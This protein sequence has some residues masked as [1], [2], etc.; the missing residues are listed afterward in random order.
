M[1]SLRHH[2]ASTTVIICL[3]LYERHRMHV[4]GKQ[5]EKRLYP[6]AEAA[7]STHPSNLYLSLSC[8]QIAGEAARLL[9]H[10]TEVQPKPMPS[11]AACYHI[12]EERKLFATAKPFAVYS[13]SV[14]EKVAWFFA[15]IF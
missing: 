4:T 2:N 1:Q 14:R 11:D 13:R 6:Q 10:I 7:S 15:R 9:H 12:F 5:D 3:R 8:S